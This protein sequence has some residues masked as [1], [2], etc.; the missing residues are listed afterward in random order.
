M[1]QAS[2]SRPASLAP[3]RFSDALACLRC[4]LLQARKH[5]ADVRLVTRQASSNPHPAPLAPARSSDASRA[6]DV[7]C[8]RQANMQ[9]MNAK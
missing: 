9:G 6:C 4:L 3:A 2:N 8:C 5:A 7:S 1:P